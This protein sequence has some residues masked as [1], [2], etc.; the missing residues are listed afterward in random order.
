MASYSWSITG[1]FPLEN[2][3]L[4]S[5]ALTGWVEMIREQEALL[6]KVRVCRAGFALA[7]IDAVVERSMAGLVSSSY[8]CE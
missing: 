6:A 2:V 3:D 5:E 8:V 4:D 7:S 1:Y